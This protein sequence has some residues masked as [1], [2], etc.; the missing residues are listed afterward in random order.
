MSLL[1][2]N[3]QFRDMKQLFLLMLLSAILLS[4]CYYTFGSWVSIPIAFLTTVLSWRPF[5]FS[6]PLFFTGQ[7]ISSGW[8]RLPLAIE[9]HRTY[10]AAYRSNV[11]RSY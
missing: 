10:P 1:G 8:L 2:T 6:L 4:V 7:F 3:Q 11:G 5:A 9:H